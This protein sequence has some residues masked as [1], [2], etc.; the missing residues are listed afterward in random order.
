[1]PHLNRPS[2]DITKWQ[3]YAFECRSDYFEASMNRVLLRTLAGETFARKYGEAAVI[4]GP[5]FSLLILANGAQ[6]YCIWPAFAA[7]FDVRRG[8]HADERVSVVCLHRIPHLPRIAGET[9]ANVWGY[10]L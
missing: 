10:G 1:M 5:A 4:E 9:V 7:M 8:T 2:R 3:L 6:F